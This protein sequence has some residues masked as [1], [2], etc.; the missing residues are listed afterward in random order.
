[1]PRK[2][3]ERASIQSSLTTTPRM[4]VRRT[5]AAALTRRTIATTPS[6][7]G[8]MR[9]PSTAQTKSVELLGEL[10]AYQVTAPKA[11]AATR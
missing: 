1:M 11:I 8:R 10:Y 4:C 3:N 2:S 5:V 9:S 6:E 7:S